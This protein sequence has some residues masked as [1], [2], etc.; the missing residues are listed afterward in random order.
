MPAGMPPM[1]A[2][3]PPAA[4][5]AAIWKLAAAA[6]AGSKP[7]G[8][9]GKPP[10]RPKGA[11][12]PLSCCCCCCCWLAYGRVGWGGGPLTQCSQAQEGVPTGLPAD[13]A[14]WLPATPSFLFLAAAAAA[15]QPL[16]FLFLFLAVSTP[17]C[18][19]P[20]RPPLPPLPP[21]PHPPGWPPCCCCAPSLSAWRCCQGPGR[22]SQPSRARP[23]CAAQTAPRGVRGRCR[24]VSTGSPGPA[25]DH[26]PPTP[27]PLPPPV[28][29][30][31]PAAAGRR[32]AL[33]AMVAPCMGPPPE[34]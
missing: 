9:M 30:G 20:P 25:V 1:P 11:P 22:S 27:H 18:A 24:R 10:P 29:H 31:R 7:V 13:P 28:L 8:P 33:L 16:L 19:M 34:Q 3:P 15:A 17:P 6:M 5:A 12:M 23:R 14:R 2:P 32:Q 26:A 21:R 4:A